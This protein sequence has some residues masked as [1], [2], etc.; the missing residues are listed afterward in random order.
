MAARRRYFWMEHVTSFRSGGGAA[1]ASSAAATL[2]RR[3]KV[4]M[5]RLFSLPT[6]CL[7]QGKKQPVQKWVEAFAG[8]C[9]LPSVSAT[10]AHADASDRSLSSKCLPGSLLG[11]SASGKGATSFIHLEIERK[12]GRIRELSA[13]FRQSGEER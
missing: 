13:D 7:K 9:D 5:K 6:L 2:Q 1:A 11:L 3:E 8:G 10:K 12:N 4:K